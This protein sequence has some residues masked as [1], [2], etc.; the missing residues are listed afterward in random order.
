PSLT[1]RGLWRNSDA[2]TPQHGV[3]IRVSPGYPPV[4]GRLHTRYA[5]VRH[6]LPPEGGIP[7]DLHVLGLPLA[8]ILSQDQ[9]LHCKVVFN[10]LKPFLFRPAVPPARGAVPYSLFFPQYFNELPEALSLHCRAYPVSAI[11]FRVCKGSRYNPYFQNFC[12]IFFPCRTSRPFPQTVFSVW[13][14]KG[15]NLFLIRKSFF[16]FFSPRLPALTPPHKKT[17]LLPPFGTAKVQLFSRTPNPQHK[18][19]PDT[20][21]NP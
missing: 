21:A 11:P 18:K 16:R 5:P 1:G 7:S 17:E 8:F 6:S 9:T 10:G 2:G 4:R 14:C 15:K 19:T 13:V 12:G 20:Y 3:L